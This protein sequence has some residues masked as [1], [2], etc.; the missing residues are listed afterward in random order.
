MTYRFQSIG[1][2]T[3]VAAEAGAFAPDAVGT[4]EQFATLSFRRVEIAGRSVLIT[5]SGIGK[6][7]AAMAAT[8]LILKYG[9]DLLMVV[10]TAGKIGTAVGHGFVITHA[11]Q[12]DYGAWRPN[13]FAHYTAGDWPIGAATLTPFAALALPEL[14]LPTA[15]IV[16]SDAFVEC[17]RRSADLRNA[18]AG[19]LVD[20]ETAAVA[21]V[22][23]RF[24]L[25]WAAIK[26]TTDDANGASAGDFTD[27]LA[28]AATI[29]ARA[30]EQAIRLLD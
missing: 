19:D 6:V 29:A 11:V 15:R 8:T 16:T 18:L 28:R 22:A 9:V 14:G 10:G 1:I 20:M 4:S 24:A 5:C 13:G 12:G 2:I 25:P 21:Q 3:G 23:T 7:N 26:A 27:N 17:P 30:A